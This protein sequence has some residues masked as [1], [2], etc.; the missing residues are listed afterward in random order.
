MNSGSQPIVDEQNPWPGLAAFDE[1]AQNF[2][3]GRAQETAVL[4]RLVVNDPLT[5]LF[6]ASGLG[7]TSLIQAGLFPALRK[8]Q[9]LPLR[10]RL[11]CRDKSA[12]LINQVRAALREQIANWRVDASFRNGDLTLWEYLH[13]AG[14]ELWSEHNHLLTPVFVLDQFEEVFTLGAENPQATEQLLIDLADLV[15]NRIPLSLANAMKQSEALTSNFSLDSQHYR[16]LLSF[17]E[18]FLPAVESWKRLMPSILR[19][20]LR[21][22]PMSTEQAFKAVHDTAPNLVDESLAR[23][24]VRFVAAAQ[25]D[26][27]AKGPAILTSAGEFS[28]EPALLSLVCDGLNRKRL[29]EHKSAFDEALLTDTGQSIVADFYERSVRDLPDHVQRFVENELITERGV[30]KPCDLDDARSLHGITDEQLGLLQNRRLLRIEHQHGTDRV[31]LIHDLLTGVVREH[32]D[33]QRKKEKVERGRKQQRQ[34]RNAILTTAAIAL[35]VVLSVAGFFLYVFAQRAR[36]AEEEVVSQTQ[37]ENS[38]FK[39]H[40][41][42]DTLLH[43]GETERQAGR[44]QECLQLFSGALDTYKQLNDRNGQVL[45]LID[46]GDAYTLTSNFADAEAAYNQAQLSSESDAQDL[47]GKIQESMASLRERQGRL[48]DALR[49]YESANKFYQGA[50]DSQASARVFERLAFEAEKSHNK[51]SAANLYQAS[52]KGYTDSGDELGKLRVQQALERVLGHWGFLQDLLSGQIYELASETV[53]VGRNV[54]GVSN[55]ISFSNQLVSRRHLAINRDFHIDDLRSRNGTTINAR[56]LPYGIGAKLSDRDI[57]VLANVEPLQFR[58]TKPAAPLNVPVDAW[59]IFIDSS[60]KSYH[61]L[62]RTEYY[63]TI[64]NK[65]II[66]HSGTSDSG[67]LKVRVGERK[68]QMFVEGSDWKLITTLKET[69]Y[70]YKSYVVNSGEWLDLYDVPVS[71]VKLTPDGKSI[72]VEGPAFQ[73]VLI[74]EAGHD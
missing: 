2:F 10:V 42:A 57:I 24:I 56:L 40:A 9:F 15:E 67:V 52:L 11:D 1:A 13:Q 19:N 38:R 63:A 54:E 32:R 62:T 8:E 53:N 41:M 72:S 3:N 58:L 36:R 31:E 33:L 39:N 69:D 49:Y 34:K 7:K 71:F 37:Q 28:V 22:L 47:Q 60:S 44:Y 4:R 23:K 43:K 5:V 65:N 61:H 70:D 51:P 50:G 66:L 14:L 55:D 27:I 48:S 20:R 21:L 74:S 45:A 25:D 35:L 46:I 73:I 18:D 26:G 29:A 64:V 30:R 6:S 16:M 59:A 17:R 68:P 12:P